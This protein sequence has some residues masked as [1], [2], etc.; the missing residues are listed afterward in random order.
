[1]Q[2][3][4]Y[5]ANICIQKRMMAESALASSTA[6]TTAPTHSLLNSASHAQLS[7]KHFENYAVACTVLFVAAPAQTHTG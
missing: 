2:K 3:G 6:Q 1:M 5:I 4:C 7:R